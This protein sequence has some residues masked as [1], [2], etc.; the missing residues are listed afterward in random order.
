MSESI[1]LEEPLLKCQPCE[2]YIIIEKLNCGIFI[3]GIL[4]SN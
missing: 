3:D 4:I 1:P 2:E